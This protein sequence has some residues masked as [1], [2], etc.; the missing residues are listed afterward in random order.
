MSGDLVLHSKLKHAP[1]KYKFVHEHA[2]D[3]QVY[4]LALF[5]GLV[6]QSELSK[7]SKKGN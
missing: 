7:V 4:R 2:Q 6:L 1:T 5:R 3:G